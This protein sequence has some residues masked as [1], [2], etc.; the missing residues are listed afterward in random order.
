VNVRSLGALITLNV[1][2][3]VALVLV[4]LTDTPPVRAQGLGR[5]LTQYT[6][7]SGRSRTGREDVAV[8]YIIELNTSRVAALMFDSRTNQMEIVAGRAIGDDFA[9]D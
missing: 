4:A 3:L 1:V 5:G 6:M 9:G 2:L 8:V 7:I